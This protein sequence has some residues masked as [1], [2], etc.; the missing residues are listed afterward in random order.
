MTPRFLSK[1]NTY[2]SGSM[3]G[4]FILNLN[5][6]RIEESSRSWIDIIDTN[7]SLIHPDTEILHY[8]YNKKSWIRQLLQL[9]GAEILEGGRIFHCIDYVI[10]HKK[11]FKSLGQLWIY[12]H[13]LFLR[14]E[15]LIKQPECT[16]KLRNKMK[17]KNRANINA[18]HFLYCNNL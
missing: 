14:K 5:F 6:C 15:K 13:G 2:I 7:W 4:R 8:K 11:E 18:S 16:I 1:V 12:F 10:Q 3:H 9:K 17:N